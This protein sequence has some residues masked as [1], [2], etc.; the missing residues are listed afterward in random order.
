[1]VEERRA[2]PRKIQS[3]QEFSEDLLA[4]DYGL[5]IERVVGQRWTEHPAAVVWDLSKFEGKSLR[6]YLVDAETNHYGQIALSEVRIT[7]S[8]GR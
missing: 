2:P 3:I 1:M 4:G 8:V 6:L 5:V 7:E